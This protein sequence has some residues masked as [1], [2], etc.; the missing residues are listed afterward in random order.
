MATIPPNTHSTTNDDR[1]AALEVSTHSLKQ[2]ADAQKEEFAGMKGALEALTDAVAKMSRAMEDRGTRV[3]EEQSN[4]GRDNGSINRHREYGEGS[5]GTQQGGLQTRFSRLD[6]PRFNGE[7]PT[8]WIYKAEQF[9]HYKK[10]EANEKV[11]LASFHLQDD[12]LEWYQWFE[13]SQPNVQWEEFTQ[14]LCIRFG[15]SDYEDF[16]EALAKLQQ[17]GTVRE[18]QT[19]F[20]RLA[21]RV[22]QWPQRALVG[23]YV[24][25]LKE[26]IRAEVKLFRPTILLHAASLARLLE[27]KLSKQR[28][29]IFTATPPRPSLSQ[30]PPYKPSLLPT[31]TPIKTTTPFHPSN[32]TTTSSTFKKLSW[33]EMQ[34]RREKGLCY[35]CDERFGPGH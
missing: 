14:A 17:T 34:V 31:P 13:Q 24:G 22:R 18:Y 1:L 16:D 3:D 30:P 8:G 15:P 10:T 32:R 19:Q 26:E 9:F 5:R 29:P 6:F 33:A 20:E 12:A 4:S 28:R 23:S 2:Q 7:N 11:L 27:E 21:A 35:N 25:G